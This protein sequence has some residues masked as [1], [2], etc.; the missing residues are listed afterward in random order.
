MSCN[1]AF[2]KPLL[3]TLQ[4][5]LIN[6]KRSIC[7]YFMGQLDQEQK[8]LLTGLSDRLLV[9]FVPIEDPIFAMLDQARLMPRFPKEALYRI[10]APFLIR[11]IDRLLWL[12]CDIIVNRDISPI[13]DLNFHS[14]LIYAM[15]DP[16]DEVQISGQIV[17]GYFM[18]GLI[19]F[20]LA[21]IR[22][23]L[24]SANV[25]Y[26]INKA[27]EATIHPDQDILNILYIDRAGFFDESVQ[28]LIWNSVRRVSIDREKYFFY[29]FPGEKKPF[30]PNYSNIAGSRFYWKYAVDIYGK[31]TR[32]KILCEQ[33]KARLK[34]ACQ[35]LISKLKTR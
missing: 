21:S 18:S 31:K 34:A 17:P 11:D 7:L 28:L 15:K 13:Y 33:K 25:K 24:T 9:V 14:S 6:T 4:S 16:A 35:I 19:L 1:D 20:N 32:R 26:A 22:Q 8:S 5:L 30:H 10:V 29:H 23:E 12:D 3:V 2:F 27:G